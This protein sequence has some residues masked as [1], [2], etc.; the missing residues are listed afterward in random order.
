[1]RIFVAGATGVIGG[2]I[3]PM[4]IGAGHQVVGMTTSAATARQVEGMGAEAAVAD[5]LDAD[6]VTTAVLEARPEVVVHQMT[7]LKAFTD[8]RRFDRAFA[9]TNRLRTEGTD[10]LLAAARTAGARRFVAQSFAGWPFARTGGP[11]K[12]EGAELDPDPPAAF[13][14]TID[15]IRHVESATLSTGG[16][17][18]IVL[19][20]GGLYGPG[21][22]MDEGGWAVEAVRRRRFPLVGEA[23]GVWSFVHAD[24]AAT[25]TLL[26]IER[27]APGIY[28][29]VDDDPAPVSDWL[30]ALA[31]AIGA[32]P[33][34]RVPAWVGRL[35]AGE[36][37]LV[38]MTEIRGASN[39]KA[40]RD[41]GWRPRF[42]SWRDGFI[43]ELGLGP[44]SRRAA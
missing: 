17:E 27:G 21:T 23:G 41:L 19:R 29:V 31:E 28:H 37:G 32:R 25:A 36:H 3:V 43:S 34:R 38:L 5:G 11:V 7:A 2:R 16:I 39:A 6:A 24:D 9:V 1:M 42:P 8:I 10:H 12:S 14:R 15:A 20:Y 40:K 4:L 13:R 26:A 22:S 30:P 44:A 33:P 35:V 18:G